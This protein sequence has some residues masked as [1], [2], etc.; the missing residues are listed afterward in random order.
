M[1]SSLNC[2]W[3]ATRC[4]QSCGYGYGRGRCQQRAAEHGVRRPTT[5]P[6]HGTC[7]LAA[8]GRPAR[9]VPIGSMPLP[10]GARAPADRRGSSAGGQH[11]RRR[12]PAR[13]SG[14]RGS[15]RATRCG[16]PGPGRCGRAW[17]RRRL[18]STGGGPGSATAG[19]GQRRGVVNLVSGLTVKQARQASGEGKE[20]LGEADRALTR[21]RTKR[22]L[23]RTEA[24][25]TRG[26]MWRWRRVLVWANIMASRN[27]RRAAMRRRSWGGSPSSDGTAAVSPAAGAAGGRQEASPHLRSRSP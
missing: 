15:G 26:S 14:G 6:R 24:T 17:P 21:A 2:G 7:R 27:E 18:C 20:G 9:G 5:R 12:L 3:S 10:S 22:A 8:R 13:G 1:Q 25:T 23:S 4:R 11:T 16:G 19:G